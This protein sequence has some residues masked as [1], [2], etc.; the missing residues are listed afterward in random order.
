MLR[1]DWPNKIEILKTKDFLDDYWHV[2]YYHDNKGSNYKTFKAKAA[3]VLND[4]D[5]NLFEK[6]FSSKFATLVD[7]LT[8]TTSKEENQMFINDIKKKQKQNFWRI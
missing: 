2:K 4:V 6:I 5:D 1:N 8:N 7:K 3:Y